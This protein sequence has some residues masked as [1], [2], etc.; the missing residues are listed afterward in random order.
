MSTSDDSEVTLFVKNLP[1]DVTPELL[2]EHFEGSKEAR[3]PTRPDGSYKGYVILSQL[4]NDIQRTFLLA[5]CLSMCIM[6]LMDIYKNNAIVQ[7]KIISVVLI[8]SKFDG[9]FST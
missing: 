2:K 6:H 7:N 1:E 8:H 5:N 4:S 9:D 3:L